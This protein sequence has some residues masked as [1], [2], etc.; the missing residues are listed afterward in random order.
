[1]P[2]SINSKLKEQYD[3]D[4]S[5]GSLDTNLGDFLDSES[6]SGTSNN[7]KWR[8]WAEGT[9]T[10]LNTRLFNKHGGSG[11]FMTRWKNW[12]AFSSTHSFNFDGSNDY[13]DCGK[14]VGNALGDSC[15][16]FSY[17]VWFKANDTNVDDGI[18]SFTDDISGGATT[19]GVTLRISANRLV[20][21]FKLDGTYE[22]LVTGFTSTDWNHAVVVYDG[23]NNANTKLYING[24]AVGTAGASGF[25]S[26]QNFANTN[27][28]IGTY[29]ASTGYIFN[30]LIDEVAV[31]DTALSASD[32]TSIYNNGKVIDLSN[33]TAYAVDRTA[34]LKLWL[35]CG[36]KA[37][38][39]STTS[40]ARS[41]FYTDFD[42]S[43]DYVDCGSSSTLK[44]I[45]NSSFTISAWVNPALDNS[46]DT[47][48]GNTWTD[49]GFHFRIE[50]NNKLRFIILTDSSN[51]KFSDSSNALSSGWTHVVGTWD[52]TN[53]KTF[54]NGIESTNVTSS[55]SLTGQ[56]S[57]RNFYIG[58][59]PQTTKPFNGQI[60][61]LSVYQTVLDAQT[62]SQ[63]AKSRFTPMRDNRF[64]VVD[65]D[66]TNDYI[67]VAD[68]DSL[69]VGT[70]DFTFSAWVN[71][72]DASENYI[73][74][75]GDA[76]NH[77]GFRLNGNRRVSYEFEVSTTNKSATDD[78][79]QLTLGQWH[80]IACVFDRDGSTFRY[81]DGVN[82][83]TN[84]VLSGNTGSLST[85]DDL[86][87]GRKY[88]GHHYFDGSIASASIYIG[89]AKSAEEIYAIY[90][91]GIT[92]DESSLSGLVGYWRMGD[93]TSSAY[94]T[95]ADSSS[96]SNDGTITN[97]ASNDIQQQMV[98]GY[99][100]GAFESSSEELG[101]SL[102]TTPN[103]AS[104][105]GANQASKDDATVDGRS[106]VRVEETST[107]DRGRID[108]TLS[109]DNNVTY[110][111]S[112][113]VF[114]Y[115][116][117][118]GNS[119]TNKNWHLVFGTDTT[120]ST[121][122]DVSSDTIKL[123]VSSY[124][125]WEYISFNIIARSGS[126]FYLL[127][128]ERVNS[129]IGTM[130]FS[131]LALKKVL[132][133]EVSDTYPAII[134]VN[135]PVLGLEKITLLSNW[136]GSDYTSTITASTNTINIEAD[137]SSVNATRYLSGAGGIL[138]GTTN[139]SAGL[140]KV[141]F[142]ASWTNAPNIKELKWYS[143]GSTLTTETIA[144]GSN[145][146]YKKVDTANG[147]SQFNIQM[148]NANQGITL[149]NL[150]IKEVS[151]NVGTMTN[152]ASDDLVYS[153]VLPDQSF[154]VGNSSPYNFIDLDGSNEYIDCGD[155]TSLDI[156]DAIT[157]SCWINADSID[158]YALLAGR[159]DSTN[160]NYYLELYT[161]EKIYWTCQG[162]SDVTVVSSTTISA[163]EWYHIAGAY[164]GSNLKI[165]ING[166]LDNSDASTG[167][168]DNDDVSFTI[169]AREAGMDRFLNGKIGQVA[170]WS[171]ALSATEVSAIY[172]LGRH[173]NLLDSYSDNLVGYWA[174]SSL[175]ASTGLSDV[176][177]GTIY[178]RSG[179]SNHGTATNTESTDLASSPNA[180]PNGYAKGDTNRSTTTP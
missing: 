41:D 16:S 116:S 128:S 169:G 137:A 146:F 113:Y 54:V 118:N 101:G 143:D 127:P 3:H 163:N 32:V 147:N 7:T 23:S 19:T 109:I 24:S 47:I 17:S 176:G 166:I 125:T 106:G 130:I 173:G 107:G 49:A 119:A 139:L 102:I 95:I 26:S 48:V 154:L 61:N 90:Q 37:E 157:L 2:E 58:D 124:D 104:A 57:T 87:I 46:D 100:M 155:G 122:P 126:N 140:Y 28:Y 55:G 108:R 67:T 120:E 35:R 168:I 74:S 179:N 148:N 11:S 112:G 175:D 91:Q 160:R 171:K 150:S 60:S 84:D 89:T 81:V 82:T 162:L 159:D 44:A 9:G 33:S 158:Q 144:S 178:D 96:N 25:P 83:G 39:E 65:F 10:S 64:S 141:S 142:D 170:V 36:D 6:A 136:T 73:F 131:D 40:I 85:S 59:N 180:E 149:A 71:L 110:Q 78:G 134:D 86:N 79:T 133:S 99:D 42:G 5:G 31:W 98:A 172:T 151:G 153:S 62:I 94:P 63:M 43:D 121:F 14:G 114:K 132:Q 72:S 22:F 161:D 129:H 93:D 105:W 68:N 51:Y 123:S 69:D 15:A 80:H 38:P 13:L 29:N 117:Y 111:L 8:N 164:D 152:Q 45:S 1:M 145:V 50:T 77:Y 92:Y 34:N 12:V 66:G 174:M 56:T 53:L 115:S 167:S 27:L 97:G 177:N 156:T 135:E 20:V 70:S 165:Y 21:T 52:G 75:K 88:S 103:S 18:I 30:G 138:T 76:D 4:D